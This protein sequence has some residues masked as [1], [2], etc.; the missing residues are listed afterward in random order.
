MSYFNNITNKIESAQNHYSDA[1]S[2]NVSSRSN[3]QDYR[4]VYLMGIILWCSEK[5]L[6]ND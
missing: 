3:L 5:E 6:I 4:N 2:G 1:V